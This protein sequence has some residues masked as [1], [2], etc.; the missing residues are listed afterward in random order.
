MELLSDNDGFTASVVRALGE[1]DP[2]WEGLDGLV[3]CG[4]HSPKDYGAKL[5]AVRG[6]RESGTPALGICKGMHY[7]AVEYARNVLRIKNAGDEEID[8][9][10]QPL[11]V[12]SMPAIRCGLYDA[13]G[14]PESHWHRYEVSPGLWD[15]FSAWDTVKAN[16]VMERMRLSGHPFYVGVQYHPEY[17]SS[18]LEPHPLLVDFLSVCRKR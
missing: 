11:V 15:M 18:K 13:G 9:G 12:R 1:I 3:V 17:G 8:P 6:A 16:G 7:M 10:A 5:E 14:R 2:D 4:S